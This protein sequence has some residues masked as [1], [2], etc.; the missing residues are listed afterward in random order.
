M[1]N[2]VAVFKENS[3]EKS[4]ESK[5]KGTVK[6]HQCK[7]HPQTIVEFELSGFKPNKTHAIHIHKFGILSVENSCDSTCDHYNPY[8]K[9][10]GSIELYGKD[11]HV[12]DLINN[13]SSDSKGNFHFSYIDDLIEV[14]DIIGR[15]VVIH[16]GTD[17]LGQFRNDFS[18]P[19]LQKGSATTGNAGSRIACSVI[20][21]A[22]NKF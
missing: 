9:L 15:S 1:L 22:P 20:G 19:K 4:A 3:I 13:L 18:N 21:I 10:H 6:F 14:S 2:A 5:I 7:S 16:G 11:R 8:N 17:D 12:G